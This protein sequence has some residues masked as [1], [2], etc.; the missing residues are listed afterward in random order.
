M[1]HTNGQIHWTRSGAQN[2]S[3]YPLDAAGAR[4]TIDRWIGER[5]ARTWVISYLRGGTADR[6]R[7][8]VPWIDERRTLA[9]A[10]ASV[11]A[12]YGTRREA[13]MGAS[14]ST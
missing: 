13:R 11:A 4:Y 6:G 5:G 3:T 2:H 12:D 7:E 14:C 9:A 10:K 1:R 8:R